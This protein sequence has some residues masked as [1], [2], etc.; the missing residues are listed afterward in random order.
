M[1]TTWFHTMILATAAVA[2]IAVGVAG[3][4]VLN[5]MRA[6]VAKK[7][8]RLASAVSPGGLPEITIERRGE[9][10]SILTRVPATALN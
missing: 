2:T 9:G 4:A 1:M 3:A 6:P 7:A 10:V 8:D 5:D